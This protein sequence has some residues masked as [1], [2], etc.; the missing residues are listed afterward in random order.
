M[1][2]Q[3]LFCGA[4]PE[5]HVHDTVGHF[6][7]DSEAPGRFHGASEGVGRRDL[8]PPRATSVLTGLN[9]LSTGLVLL[10]IA[11][12]IAVRLTLTALAGLLP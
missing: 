9:L 1:A 4:A 12:P 2:C 7:A 3:G 6:S 5:G 10:P 11:L 8:G